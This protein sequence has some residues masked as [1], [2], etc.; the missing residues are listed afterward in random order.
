MSSNDI[1]NYLL[2]GVKMKMAKIAKRL[3]ADKIISNQS[4]NSISL[5]S[6]NKLLALN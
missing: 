6:P 3:Y 2:N 5:E 4:K 1:V